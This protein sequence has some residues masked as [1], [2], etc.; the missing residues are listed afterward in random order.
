MFTK[1]ISGWGNYKTIKSTIYQPRNIDELKKIIKQNKKFTIRSKGRSYGDSSLGKNIISLDMLKE[2]IELDE[3]K[4]VIHCSAN[5]TIENILNQTLS[6][7]WFLRVTPG[8]KFISVGGLIASDVHGKN[9]HKDGTFCNHLLEI[10]ILLNNG[11]VLRI[12]KKKNAN[13]FKSTCG[14]MGL[15]GVV[16]SAKFKMLKIKSSYIIQDT[17]KTNSLKETINCLDKFNHKKYVVGWIDTANHNTLGR[18]VIYTG[19]HYNKGGF[20]LKKK[21]V[22]NLKKFLQF[23]S[24]FSSNFI[25]KIMS[26]FYFSIHKNRKKQIVHSNNFFYPLDTIKGWNFFYGNRGFIQFQVLI[27]KKNAIKNIYKII[28][29]LIKNNQI[30]FLSTIKKLGIKNDNY[31]SFPDN[32]YTL[33]MDIKNNKKMKNIFNK[34]EKF[35]I[36]IDSKV[37][38]TKDSIMSKN[39][40]YNSYK[41]LGKFKKVFN[42]FNKNNKFISL[43]SERLKI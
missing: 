3:K 15:T 35:L 37:Y 20:N 7:G 17:I 41:D 34:L 36:K 22:Y 2:F 32:G 30:S 1:F 40:F 28:D 42:K 4:G 14:G 33:T 8:S 27:K 5:L 21:N 10:E 38:L 29:Y 6:K 9:H 11:R 16:L 18:S 19:E 13:F 31:L 43:Q 24:I 25:L 26:T 12:N 23:F 39:F